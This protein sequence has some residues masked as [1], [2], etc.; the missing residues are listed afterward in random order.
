MYWEYVTVTSMLIECGYPPLVCTIFKKYHLAVLEILQC[1][2]ANIQNKSI[3]YN[4]YLRNSL[5][6]FR[7]L[8]LPS[9]K[10]QTAEGRENVFHL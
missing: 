10:I 3:K 2:T 9:T 4:M 1:H 5:R 6:D 8:T 7:N